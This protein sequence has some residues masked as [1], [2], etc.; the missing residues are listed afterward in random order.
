MVLAV[1]LFVFDLVVPSLF[2][3]LPCYPITTHGTRGIFF[4]FDVVVPTLPPILHAVIF[5]IKSCY[6]IITTFCCYPII[7]LITLLPCYLVTPIYI[8]PNNT[9]HGP[10]MTSFTIHLHDLTGPIILSLQH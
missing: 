3:F 2:V 7:T 1:F 6:S 8:Y 5:F 4:V 9:K 10:I